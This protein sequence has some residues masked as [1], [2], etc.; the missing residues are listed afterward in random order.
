MKVFTFKLGVV[1]FVLAAVAG[2]QQIPDSDAA[3]F[4][5]A[6]TSVAPGNGSYLAQFPQVR[7]PF[8]AGT[9]LGG[10]TGVLGVEHA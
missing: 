10:L 1:L 2:A 5:P 3:S 8:D 4:P 9:P 6:L 7:G